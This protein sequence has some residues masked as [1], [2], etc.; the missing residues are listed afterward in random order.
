MAAKRETSR[1]RKRRE[2]KL[3]LRGKKIRIESSRQ[4]T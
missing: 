3:K 2:G 1:N 4:R